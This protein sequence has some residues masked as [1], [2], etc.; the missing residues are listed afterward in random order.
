[1]N[2]LVSSIRGRYAGNRSDILTLF[3]PFFFSFWVHLTVIRQ[4]FV[5]LA[6]K[7]QNPLLRS[8]LGKILR[9]FAWMYC[10]NQTLR[11]ARYNNRNHT[12]EH[13]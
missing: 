9:R 10:L 6:V 7:K 8:F 12:L 1:M 11:S 13:T 4:V 5:S 2:R 3:F